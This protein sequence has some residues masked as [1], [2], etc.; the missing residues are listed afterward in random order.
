MRYYACTIQ[1]KTEHE[2]KHNK[3]IDITKHNLAKLNITKHD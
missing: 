3:T 1:Y 2:T